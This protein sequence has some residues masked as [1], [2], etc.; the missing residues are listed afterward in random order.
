MN[1][2]DMATIKESQM[3]YSIIW[4]S[5]NGYIKILKKNSRGE[6]EFYRDAVSEEAAHEII[7]EDME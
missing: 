7:K 3:G 4:D 6:W 5:K 1:T 2:N